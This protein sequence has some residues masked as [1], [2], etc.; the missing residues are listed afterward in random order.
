M[1]EEVKEGGTQSEKVIK[2]VAC[3]K[4]DHKFLPDKLKKQ[5]SG[6]IEI[7]YFECPVC[8]QGYEVCRTNP[9]LRKMQQTIQNRKRTI[10]NQVA[11]RGR[12]TPE[13]VREYQALVTEF[14]KK[15][16]EFNGKTAIA[17]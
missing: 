11:S 12:T 8:N 5:R 17:E 6:E 15:F 7:T 13:R 1:A 14:R 10:L 3:D 4:C 16:D 9:E 2:E